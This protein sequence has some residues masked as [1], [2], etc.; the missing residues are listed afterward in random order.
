MAS[1][2]R[3]FCSGSPYATSIWSNETF[4]FI[5]SD[6]LLIL[7]YQDNN[8][9]SLLTLLIT[10]I[11]YPPV[12]ELFLIF[13]MNF[14]KPFIYISREKAW[15]FLSYFSSKYYR[16]KNEPWGGR[17]INIILSFTGGRDGIA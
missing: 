10:F 12:Y 16:M 17:C 4:N 11:I 5:S 13:Y 8:S 9:R 2:R 3:R 7:S 14:K 1:A 15:N 6:I